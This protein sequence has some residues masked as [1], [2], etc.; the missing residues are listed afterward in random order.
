MKIAGND[1]VKAF[2]SVA[3]KFIFLL[4]GLLAPVFIC[5]AEVIKSEITNGGFVANFY[6]DPNITNKFGI[7]FLGGSEGGLPYPLPFL[8]AKGYPTLT[9]AYFKERGLPESL[10]SI[11][12]EYFDKPIAWLQHNAHISS[13]NIVVIGGSRGAELALLL[14]SLKPAIKGVIAISPSSVVWSG[15][16]KD[17]STGACPSWTLAGK[18]IP[19]MPFDTNDVTS[20]IYNYFVR[21]LARTNDV[22]RAAIHVENI[23]GPILLACGQDDPV[24]PSAE[25]ANTICTRLRDAGFKYKYTQLVYKNAG[26]TLNERFMIG[27]TV[28]G[29][30]EA[31]IDLAKQILAFLGGIQ[32]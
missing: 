14:G 2:W 31:R 10:E 13:T 7:V 11:P 12:L 16:P 1:I 23:R 25:M 9:L 8:A 24:W 30:K 4:I 27:G 20:G 3:G 15:L 22:E 32:N 6:C 19:Y 18:P 29:N 5:R 28:E 17:F 26:H 21:S